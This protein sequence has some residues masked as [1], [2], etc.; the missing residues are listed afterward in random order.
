MP[1]THVSDISKEWALLLYALMKHMPMNVGSIIYSF[2]L[3]CSKITNAGFSFPSLI[4]ALC[5]RAGVQYASREKLIQPKLVLNPHFF[6]SLTSGS[7]NTDVQREKVPLAP[8][9]SSTSQPM[10]MEERTR[11]VEEQV[12]GI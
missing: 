11:R 12:S 7:G 8:P 4:T 3:H 2:I 10:T 1:S 6:N 5:V 9:S